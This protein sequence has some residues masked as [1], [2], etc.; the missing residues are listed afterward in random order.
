M[1]CQYCGRA[2]TKKCAC[3]NATPI[4]KKEAISL[5]ILINIFLFTPLW[6]IINYHQLT[7]NH[8]I[9]TTA[10]SMSAF[11]LLSYI[12]GVFKKKSYVAL[13]FGCHQKKQ[14]CI[15]KA[16][17]C[18]RCLGIILGILLTSLLA[19]VKINPH[20]LLILALPLILDGFI[21]QFTSYESNHPK[22]LISGI[23]FAP[24]IV[25]LFTYM[26]TYIVKFYQIIT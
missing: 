4:A 6:L 24:T 18:S 10:L 1:Y 3:I 26:Y 9:A 14:R 5:L 20:L 22:R 21:Q 19:F 7:F 12:L 13:L 8:Y 17:L 11:I 25:I 23:L 16:L 2:Y 15:H